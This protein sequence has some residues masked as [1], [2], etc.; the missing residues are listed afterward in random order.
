MLGAEN[1]SSGSGPRRSANE[2]NKKTTSSRTDVSSTSRLLANKIQK[3]IARLGPGPLSAPAPSAP[4]MDFV[5]P[6]L[7]PGTT[8][9]ARV[10]RRS[11]PPGCGAWWNF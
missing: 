3:S 6:V 11:A 4:L 7:D 9:A 8:Q 5:A 2:T 10:S 1:I